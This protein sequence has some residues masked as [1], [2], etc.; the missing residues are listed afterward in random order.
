MDRTFIPTIYSN[1]INPILRFRWVALQLAE[2][3]KCSSEYQVMHQLKNLP[4]GLDDIYKRIL[5]AIDGKYHADTLTFLQ[6]LAFSRRPMA[7]EEV[8]EAVTVDFDLDDGPIFTPTKRYTD[9]RDVLARCS[10][11]VNESE[12]KCCRLNPTFKSFLTVMTGTI[13]LSHFSVK[14]YLLSDR[15]EKKFRISEKSSHSRISEISVAYLLQFQSFE[16]LTDAILDSSPLAWYAAEHWIDHAKSGGMDSGVRKLILQLFISEAAPLTN[17]IRLWNIDAFHTSDLSMDKA[18]VYSPL[19]YAALAGM[20]QVAF[21]L[22]E[23]GAEVNALGGMF[24]N[25][26]QAVSFKGH[27]VIMKLLLENGAEVNAQGGEYNWNALQAASHQGHEA[28]VKVLLEN[29]AEVNAQGREYN[30]NALQAASHQGHEA[31]VKV[32]LE[33]GAEVNAQGG[34]FGNALQA[35]SSKG[36]EAIVE[37]LLEEGAEVNAQGGIFGNALHAASYGCHE[38]IVKVLLE[39]GAEVNAQGGDFGNALQA[40]SYRGHEAIVKVL[41]EKGAE[42]NAQGGDFRN[43]LQAASYVG[44]EV[45]VKVLL[46][47]GAKVNAQGGYYGNALQAA[48]CK[49][50]EVI[51]KVL[52]EKGAKVN[53]QGG[54]YGN[55]LQAASCEGHEAIVKVLLEKGAGVNAQGGP[56]GNSLQAASYFAHEAIVKVLLEN[57]AEVNAVTVEGVSNPTVLKLLMEA[58][59]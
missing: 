31:I 13:K 55:A 50:H 5:K 56:F 29:G 46:E 27:E 51:V 53:A 45:I 34:H 42:V 43:A 58:K 33:K 20:E 54:Y 14:E 37:V 21:D 48:S 3:A 39:K 24:G 22:L 36:H 52:L 38:A 35:A 2:L 7:I 25:A 4:E 17:W 41:L 12:G 40:A 26:L 10:S 8:A 30:W 11:L 23:Q 1:V 15:I 19:Y 16:P 6:W 9:P 32:L 57:G 59:Q 49:G 47:K 28:I 18:K 44:H